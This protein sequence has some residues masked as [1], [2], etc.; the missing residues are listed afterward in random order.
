MTYFKTIVTTTN[1]HKILRL[2]KND[3]AHFVSELKKFRTSIFRD[4]V[5]LTLNGVS[6]CLNAIL[7]VK[8]INEWT[9]EE[10]LAL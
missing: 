8:F 7:A 10:L 4:V 9:G 6:V 3:V 1:G 2:Q 5:F